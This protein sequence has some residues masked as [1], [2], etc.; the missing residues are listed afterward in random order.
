MIDKMKKDLLNKK[1]VLGIFVSILIIYFIIIVVGSG[2]LFTKEGIIYFILLVAFIAA[3]IFIVGKIL[4][5][6]K[7]D[8]KIQEII[9][10]TERLYKELKKH[11]TIID[12]GKELDISIKEDPNNPGKKILDIKHGKKIRQEWRSKY[13]TKPREKEKKGHSTTP[14]PQ[15]GQ[16][17]ANPDQSKHLNTSSS[18]SFHGKEKG[19]R[20]SGSKS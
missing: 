15:K 4:K 1:N 3:G 5:E 20:D 11:G 12:D 13:E 16:N 19:N 2:A 7:A 18:T 10:D 8:K 9:K 17:K 14:G 6:R